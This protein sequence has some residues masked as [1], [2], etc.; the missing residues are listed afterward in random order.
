MTTTDVRR[1]NDFSPYQHA[2][3]APPRSLGWTVPAVPVSPSKMSTFEI[4]QFEGFQHGTH[5]T[6]S[7][8]SDSSFKFD[9]ELIF[10]TTLL[11]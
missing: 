4:G 11:R 6:W 10:L 1:T 3:F 2:S 5:T 7:F 9:E 8:Y